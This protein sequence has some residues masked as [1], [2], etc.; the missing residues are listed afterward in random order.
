[1]DPSPNKKD[2]KIHAALLQE[3]ENDSRCAVDTK[4]A[5]VQDGDDNLRLLL[6]FCCDLAT[7]KLGGNACMQ[8]TE[9][10]AAAPAS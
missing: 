8:R 1:M 6:L 7:M 4:N 5:A 9:I 3:L 2:E 10:F